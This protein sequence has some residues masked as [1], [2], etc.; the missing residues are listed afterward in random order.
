MAG[1][2]WLEMPRHTYRDGLDNALFSVLGAIQEENLRKGKKK[3]LCL[4][5]Y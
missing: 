3:V 1:A 2:G 4:A 5:A